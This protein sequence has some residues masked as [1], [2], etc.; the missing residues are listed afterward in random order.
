M[1]HKAKKVKQLRSKHFQQM[2]LAFYKQKNVPE[3]NRN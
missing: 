2:K 1:P 3:T